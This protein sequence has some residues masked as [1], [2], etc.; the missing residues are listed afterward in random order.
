[1]AP[2][3]KLA[4]YFAFAEF[5]VGKIRTVNTSAE[6]QTYFKIALVSD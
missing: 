3:F 4:R 6:T 1:M 5:E 2:S